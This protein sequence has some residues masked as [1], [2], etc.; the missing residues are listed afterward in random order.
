MGLNKNIIREDGYYWVK[1]FN[2]DK[3]TICYFSNDECDWLSFEFT[4]P[5]F[6]NSFE[7]I[8]ERKIERL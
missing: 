8:D 1:I 5:L 2:D 6:D 4:K 7:E 3:F